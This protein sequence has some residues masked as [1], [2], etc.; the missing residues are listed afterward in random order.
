MTPL[1]RLLT[2]D[3][4]LGSEIDLGHRAFG[5]LT[6][7]EERRRRALRERVADGRLL[8]GFDGDRLVASASYWDMRQWWHGAPVPM[9]GVASAKGAPEERA[10]GTG[11]ALMTGL[12][13]QIAGRGYP[14]AALYPASLPFYRSLGWETAGGQYE[15]VLAAP[16]LR[17]LQLSD[18]R[19]S[20]SSAGPDVRRAGPGDAAEIDKVIAE[21]TAASRACGPVN[22]SVSATATYLDDPALFCY[23]APDG[24][25]AYSWERG[26]EEI[27]AYNVI[28]GSAATSRTWWSILASHGTM[29]TTVRACVGPDDPLLWLTTDPGLK[30][31]RPWSWMLR[32]IDAPAAIAARGYPSGVTAS[33]RLTVT[34]DQLPANTGD[35]LLHIT[36]GHATLVRSGP[37]AGPAAPAEISPSDADPLRLGARGLAALY[38]GTPLGTLR[39]AGLATGGTPAADEP[40]DEAFAARSYMLDYF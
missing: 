16:A 39:Q 22:F 6:G 30:V 1:F 2:P 40:L 34:D 11:G 38:A 35:W 5:P 10:R 20:P 13:A 15:A 7:P 19:E 28:A 12:L 17:R 9:A 26:H 27:R 37:A 33:V 29:A 3:D 32:L 25:L 8:G 23:L 36:A 24:F 18:A 14:L 21:V 4:D 31:T